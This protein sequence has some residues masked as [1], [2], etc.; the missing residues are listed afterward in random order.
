ESGLVHRAVN[1]V[2]ALILRSGPKDRVSK[3]EGGRL[4]AA[5]LRDAAQK[6]VGDARERA[7]AARL[8]S[9]RTAV[10]DIKRNQIST[11]EKSWREFSILPRPRRAAGCSAASPTTRRSA[12]SPAR[13]T[14]A[15]PASRSAA[16]SKAGC[17]G[18]GS[19]ISAACRRRPMRRSR[20]PAEIGTAAGRGRGGG[21]GV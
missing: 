14:A 21:Q 1:D 8:L 9:M 16:A 12:I 5:M 13:S 3:D 2:A 19:T 15:I 7:F 4:L 11:T 10:V 18:R 20:R 17:A 6:R